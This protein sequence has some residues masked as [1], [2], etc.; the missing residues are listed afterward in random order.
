MGPIQDVVLSGSGLCGVAAQRAGQE[1]R[2]FGAGQHHVT[3]RVVLDL[4]GIQINDEPI[5]GENGGR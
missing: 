1:I 3:A 4:P 2:I 5:E